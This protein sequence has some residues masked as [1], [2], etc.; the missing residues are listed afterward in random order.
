[1]PALP[2]RSTFFLAFGLICLV[3]SGY[4]FWQQHTPRRLAFAVQELPTVESGQAPQPVSLRIDS[5]NLVLPILPA[6]LQEGEWE[7]T[8]EGVSYLTE[9]PVPGQPGNSVL[10]GHNWPNL[11]GKLNQLKMGDTIEIEFAEGS[12]QTFTVKQRHVVTPDQTH[13]LQPTDDTR[14]TLYTCT[15]LFDRHRLVVVATPN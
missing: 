13:V 3:I 11:L 6:S 10:Y 7:T 15:G 8:S 9:T 5:V 2:R 4:L 1:M 12:T 14:L